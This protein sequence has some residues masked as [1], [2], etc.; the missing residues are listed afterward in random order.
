MKSSKGK[1]NI[2]AAPKWIFVIVVL[3]VAVRIALPYGLKLYINSTLDSIPGYYGVIE[4]IDISLWRGAYQ[5]EGVRLVKLKGSEREP[6]FSAD[7]IDI[8]V[9]WRAILEGRLVSKISLYEPKLL[10]IVRPSKSASQTS[11]DSSWQDKVK[12]LVPLEINRFLI[13]EGLVRYKDETRTP[14]ID[15]DLHDLWLEAENITNATGRPDRLPSTLVAQARIM[16]T[17][18][19]KLSSH[20]DVLSVPAQFDVNA[21]VSGLDLKEANEFTKAYAG[22]DFEKGTLHVTMELAATKDKIDGYVKTLAKNVDVLDVSKELEKGDS[23]GHLL[24]EG[25]AG[26][27]MAIFKNHSRDQFAARVPI[28]GARADLKIGTWSA[29]GSV[30]KNTFIKA[31]DPKYEDTVDYKSAKKAEK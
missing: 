3:L 11:V 29:I 6:L 23:P 1:W 20:M 24:W 17:G 12:G 13:F 30:L 16:K 27:V 5:I 21:S 25:L 31:L 15:V 18:R 8:S 9:D 2:K 7:E 19:L 22:F 28:D 26:S 14:R 10:F 4:D